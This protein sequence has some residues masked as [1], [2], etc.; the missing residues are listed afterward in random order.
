MTVQGLVVDGSN[1]WVDGDKVNGL[2]V[3]GLGVDSKN[4]GVDSDKVNKL[5]VENADIVR[6]T[7]I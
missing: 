4:D 5:M 7:N 1:D 2:T 3:Q 6:C